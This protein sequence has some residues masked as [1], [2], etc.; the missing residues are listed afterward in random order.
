MLD[1]AGL[2]QIIK[3]YL[4]GVPRLTVAFMILPVLS[5]SVLGG[6][7][8]RNG[9]MLSFA[10]FIYPMTADSLPPD[11]SLADYFTILIKEMTLGLVIGYMAAVPF[12]I[13]E[14][15]GFFID[16]QRGAAMASSVNPIM[17][18]QT[19]PLGI[20]MTQIMVTIFVI[21]GAFLSLILV[22][23][24]SYAVW[25]VGVLLPQFMTGLD[26]FILSQLDLVMELVV[27]LSAPVIL[28]MFLS[29][30]SLALISR[31]APQ[32]NVFFLAMPVKS[33]IALFVLI[34][35]LK[36]LVERLYDLIEKTPSQIIEFMISS[37]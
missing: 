2:E 22:M 23:V 31:F 29:E 4:L 35:Y 10:L 3:T 37:F 24:Q 32:L 5:K 18:E 14:G 34:L 11:L 30:F 20:F 12:W 33:A 15:V 7:M 26:T 28:A 9:A 36:Y 6:S 8:V 27:V 1:A 17:G 16:N 19:S 21:S 13:A 25:P